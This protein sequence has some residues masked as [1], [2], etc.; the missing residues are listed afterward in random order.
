MAQTL[1]QL[2]TSAQQRANQ[3]NKTLV[4]T[5]EWNRYIQEAVD[6]LYDLIVSSFPHYYL[7]SFAF[8]LSSSNQQSIAALTP[9]FYKL[10]GLDFLFA[11]AQRPLTVR[12]INF[13]ERNRFAATNFAG[14]YT[15]WYTPRPPQLT[16]DGDTLDFILDNWS[17]YVVL[18]AAL[19]ALP[20]E[21]SPT[22]DL[23][24]EKAI[25]LDRIKTAAP[26]RDGEPGQAADLMTGDRNE[27]GRRYMLEGANLILL[28]SDVWDWA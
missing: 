21:E 25:Q 18:T 4:A 19:A 23:L 7:S 28:G 14:S 20:K 11:G 1:A 13:A 5:S 10:R 8:T 15:L 26:N 17:K 16:A 6:E 3:E 24:G 12:P 27:S 22:D 9:I 2:R